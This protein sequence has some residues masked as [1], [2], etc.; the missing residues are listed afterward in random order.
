MSDQVENPTLDDLT[1]HDL[2]A[3]MAL[4]GMLV[5]PTT[6]T[7][8]HAEKMARGA[9]TMADAMLAERARRKP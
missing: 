3:G 4:Q 8:V 9:Y 2:Y 7:R 1:L 5:S 6:K